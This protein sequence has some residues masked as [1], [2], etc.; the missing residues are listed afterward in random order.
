PSQ[1]LPE[2]DWPA[3]TVSRGATRGAS[4]FDRSICKTA[5]GEPP[6]V[7]PL[8]DRGFERESRVQLHDAAQRSSFIQCNWEA[9]I[10]TSLTGLCGFE[11]KCTLSDGFTCTRARRG[12]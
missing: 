2:I 12:I 4:G 5:T 9:S 11:W 6:C 7:D 1:G 8:L 10:P 3:G